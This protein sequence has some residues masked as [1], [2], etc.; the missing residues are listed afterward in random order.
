MT[1]IENIKQRAA[2]VKDATQAG[3]NTATRV[4]GV[5]VDLADV[6]DKNNQATNEALD[7]KAT[8]AELDEAK[9]TQA[10]KDSLQD[11]ELAKKADSEAMTT[12]LAKKFD[13]TSVAQVTGDSEELVMSQKAV[14]DKLS[15]LYSDTLHL[16]NYLTTFTAFSDEYKKGKVCATGKIGE[17][18][19]IS[20]SVSKGTGLFRIQCTKGDS[21]DIR[22]RVTSQFGVVVVDDNNVILEKVNISKEVYECNIT[23]TADNA[24]FIIINHLG[25]EETYNDRY[26]LVVKNPIHSSI[27]EIK[28]DLSRIN[29]SLKIEYNFENCVKGKYINCENLGTDFNTL[30]VSDTSSSYF[31]LEC[32]SNDIFYV[33]TY[34]ANKA[35]AYCFADANGNLMQP[36]AEAATTILEYK[37]I[38]PASAK[39]LIVNLRHEGNA[40]KQENFRVVAFNKKVESLETKVESLETNVESLETNVEDKTKQL[41]NS[42]SDSISNLRALAL[43]KYN[44]FSLKEDFSSYN[45]SNNY[46]TVAGDVLNN[47]Y[48]DLTGYIVC[49]E[50]DLFY[51]KG[52]GAG[53]V[54]CGY[55]DN[56]GN[57]FCPILTTYK[58]SNAQSYE[59]IVS[60]PKGVN[61]VRAWSRNSHHPLTQTSLVFNSV[62]VD[63]GE[64]EDYIKDIVNTKLQSN[65][66]REVSEKIVSIVNSVKPTVDFT[67][68]DSEYY[69]EGKKYNHTSFFKAPEKDGVC[70]LIISFP[71][72]GITSENWYSYM[73]H[74]AI[75]NELGYAVL[76][77]QGWSE[78]WC[79][80]KINASTNS[81]TPV[82]NW[83]ALEEA[84]KAYQYV[85]D[86]YSW[87]DKNGVYLY[88]ESQGGCLAENF[89]ELANIPV[90]A[91]VL[92]SPVI[93]LKYHM[94]NFRQTAIYAFYGI[95]N[96]SW[97]EDKVVG[98]DPYTRNMV[99]EIL[100]SGT[101]PSS[102]VDF[103]Q[104][105]AK[106]IRNCKSP[107]LILLS[108]NDTVLSP[109][110]TKG[111]IKAL[112]NGGSLCEVKMYNLPNSAGHGIVQYTN[113]IGSINNVNV[114]AG[115][116][117]ILEFYKRYGGYDYSL[118]PLSS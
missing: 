5:L 45:I 56:S 80:D 3:E 96:S 90:L 47:Q 114:T 13:K 84:V 12:E 79:H 106:K 58:D 107:L 37:L 66:H 29:N 75:L 17:R 83:M 6:V 77:I 70:K 81:V 118:G 59:R 89:A 35:R 68:N 48:C 49:S 30:I 46:I 19:N 36:Q 1:T 67:P 73:N 110:V 38:A 61:Y 76:T 25:I 116:V 50:N 44:S 74:G 28:D 112:K 99:G 43:L 20:D 7:K 86:K 111:Y 54:I 100:G 33:T 108:D 55:S 52:S 78:E 64:A 8:K 95:E 65:Y 22:S 105:T 97:D 88:G 42:F 71:G 91:T 57:G 62:N 72:G 85:I 109:S 115:L 23:I 101:N 16:K 40:S 117:Q 113:V 104:V 39:Y 92:D 103:N 18:I 93:S 32:A 34:G 41:E 98:C 24:N 31:L 63:K 4:G 27:D 102:I 69:E 15:D 94:W 21:F 10:E 51:Y 26:A 2:T 14:S 11:A 87:I 9:K 53:C 60:I 82:G